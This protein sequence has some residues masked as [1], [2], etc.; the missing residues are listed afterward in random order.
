M[1]TYPPEM[2]QL[3]FAA[4]PAQ[5]VTDLQRLIAAMT[6]LPLPGAGQPA[7]MVSFQEKYLENTQDEDH[8]N[9]QGLLEFFDPMTAPAR[10]PDILHTACSNE[11]NLSMHAYTILQQDPALPGTIQIGQLVGCQKAHAAGMRRL[12][13]R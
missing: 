8:A 7:R 10:D 5:E 4:T 1:T 12:M 2:L 3:I 6:T 11:S 9:L 13:S